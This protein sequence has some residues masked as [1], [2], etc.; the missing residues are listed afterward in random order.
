MEIVRN[1]HRNGVT[2]IIVEH[3]LNIAAQFCD[4]SVFLEEGHIRFEGRTLDLIKRDDIA[5]AVSFG[6]AGR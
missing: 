2:T 3:S 6:A 4:R 1:L 5:R